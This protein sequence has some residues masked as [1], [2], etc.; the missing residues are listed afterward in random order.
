MSLEEINVAIDNIEIKEEEEIQLN[1]EA[2]EIISALEGIVS[3]LADVDTSLIYEAV[4]SFLS[5]EDIDE[6]KNIYSNCFDNVPNENQVKQYVLYLF[7]VLQIPI[8]RE[9]EDGNEYL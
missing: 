3:E 1:Q 4:N 5:K 6:M 9:V 2:Q 7:N 8:T